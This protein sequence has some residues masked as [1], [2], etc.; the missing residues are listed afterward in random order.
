MTS[1]GVR[2]ASSDEAAAFWG[3]HM[4]HYLAR[5]DGVDVAMGT[6]VRIH[7][8][9]WAYFDVRDNLPAR[10]GLLVIR[11]A[12]R[13]MAAA[14]EPVYVAANDGVHEDAGRLLKA[15]GFTP[16]DQYVND[17]RV[18]VWQN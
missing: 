10:A 16:T 11:A 5:Y 8:K 2:L 13:Q 15:C 14:G 7:D 12:R 1:D 4:T 3:R 9:L 6:L 18:W 17:K